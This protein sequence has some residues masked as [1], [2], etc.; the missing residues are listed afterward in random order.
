MELRR[1]HQRWEV[2]GHDCGG[3][4]LLA[5]VHIERNGIRGHVLNAQGKEIFRMCSNKSHESFVLAAD[6]LVGRGSDG[7][8]E[9]WGGEHRHG[10]GAY[11]H[12]RETSKAHHQRR[13]PPTPIVVLGSALARGH[14]PLP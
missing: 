8:H 3:T 12:T 4:E 9:R 11:A 10:F 1:G 13:A 6:G 14:R 5:G 2:C 7:A